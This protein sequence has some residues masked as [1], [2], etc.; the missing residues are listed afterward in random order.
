[1]ARSLLEIL[2]LEYLLRSSLLGVLVYT[3]TLLG[4]I[5]SQV[6]SSHQVQVEAYDVFS[7]EIEQIIA[8][9]LENFHRLHLPYPPDKKE[10][11][12]LLQGGYLLYYLPQPVRQEL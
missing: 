7:G 9:I 4:V 3:L 11:V 6:E 12:F 8:E 5:L 2:K 1:M 10:G